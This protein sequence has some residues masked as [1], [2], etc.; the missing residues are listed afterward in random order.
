MSTRHRL[1]PPRRQWVAS[2]PAR[3]IV[4]GLSPLC[5]EGHFTLKIQGHLAAKFTLKVLLEWPS[6]RI[7]V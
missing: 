2:S 6:D 3:A 4:T 1:G 5:H 7:Y